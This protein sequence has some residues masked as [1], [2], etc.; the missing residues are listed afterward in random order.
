MEN[1]G[2]YY[3]IIYH[4]KMAGLWR[5]GGQ[6][7][8][9]LALIIQISLLLQPPQHLLHPETGLLEYVDWGLFVV[10]MLRHFAFGRRYRL[11]K[12]FFGYLYQC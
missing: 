9:G 2:I 4:I 5:M 3:C 7:G 12:Q 8:H 11:V 10:R 6:W 1:A